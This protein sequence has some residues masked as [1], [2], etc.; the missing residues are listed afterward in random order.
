MR[1]R[2]VTIVESGGDGDSEWAPFVSARLSGSNGS[3]SALYRSTASDSF[4]S[5]DK[6]S[7]P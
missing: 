2:P 7:F 1:P 6:S 3:I 5:N 4:P